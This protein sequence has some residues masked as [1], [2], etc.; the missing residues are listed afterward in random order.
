MFRTVNPDEQ[1]GVAQAWD[2]IFAHQIKDGPTLKSSCVALV[3]AYLTSLEN[4]YQSN[5]KVIG[6]QIEAARRLRGLVTASV[7]Q[8]LSRVAEMSSPRG[9]KDF[10][11]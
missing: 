10:L 11:S 8:E 3:D 6:P 7:E 5:P 4:K 2:Q 9:A 1:A